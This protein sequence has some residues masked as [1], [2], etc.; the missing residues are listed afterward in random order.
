MKLG[1]GVGGAYLVW[2]KIKNVFTIVDVS[3][4]S[5]LISS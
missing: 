3:I 1:P 2:M 5:T 4:Y